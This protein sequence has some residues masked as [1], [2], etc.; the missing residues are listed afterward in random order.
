[1]YDFGQP[2]VWYLRKYKFKKYFLKSS[3]KLCWTQTTI[4][5]NYNANT[6]P[7]LNRY[8]GY[9]GRSCICNIY[10]SRLE[11]LEVLLGYD[12]KQD[13]KW[14]YNMDLNCD[15]KRNLRDRHSRHSSNSFMEREW[16]ILY[17]HRAT[18]SCFNLFL[19]TPPLPRPHCWFTYFMDSP[20]HKGCD[21]S[22]NHIGSAAIIN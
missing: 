7:R 6:H 14:V 12:G 4:N 17:F 16:I 1:M 11:M 5:F 18:V 20:L 3:E 19:Y 21:V 13:V 2:P 22:K 15:G 9:N 8:W 10:F